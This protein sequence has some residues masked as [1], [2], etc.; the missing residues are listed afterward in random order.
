MT[1]PGL[2]LIGA[3]ANAQLKVRR[4]VDHLENSVRL[5][6]SFSDAFAEFCRVAQK[7]QIKY[8]FADKDGVL[9]W[10]EAGVCNLNLVAE[11]F[12][13]AGV[14]GL[15]FVLILTGSSYEQNLQFLNSSELTTAFACN[16]RIAASP[17]IILA[18]NG[19]LRI[20]VLTRGVT[21]DAAIIDRSRLAWLKGSCE[22]ELLTLVGKEVLPEFGLRWSAAADDQVEAIWIPKKRTMVTLNIPR[23]FRDGR[24]YRLSVEGRGV[25]LAIVSCMARIA[26]AS[27][28]K[29]AI[30]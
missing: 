9:T 12:R 3:P 29:Y 13:C 27:G 22:H 30:L 14:A 5:S 15:P 6:G 10:K 24:D 28:V 19:T 2:G 4:V 18:E 17:Y 16:P 23:Q 21:D 25:G 26:E 1:I 8:V 11:L 7:R 20:N